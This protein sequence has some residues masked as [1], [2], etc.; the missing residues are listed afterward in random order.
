MMKNI[1]KYEDFLNEKKGPCW[2]GY[3]QVGMKT[4]KGKMVPNCVK[5]NKSNG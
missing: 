2:L 3:K 5:E 1:I 4:K